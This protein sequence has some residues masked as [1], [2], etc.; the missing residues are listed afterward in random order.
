M[1]WKSTPERYDFLEIIVHHADIVLN[2][3]MSLFQKVIQVVEENFDHNLL[4]LLHRVS[5][6]KGLKSQDGKKQADLERVRT[7]HRKS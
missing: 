2:M 1:S 3:F 4:V 7:F 5:L 6:W